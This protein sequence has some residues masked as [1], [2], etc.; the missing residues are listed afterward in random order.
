MISGVSTSP[1][2]TL[3]PF[4]SSLASRA[5]LSQEAEPVKGTTA[6]SSAELTEEEKAQVEQLKKIDKEVR[7]HEQA[8]KNAGGQYAGS[9]TFSYQAGPD[10][11]RYA[12]SGEVPIDIAPVAGDPKATIAKM[13]AVSAAAMAPAQPSGQD[14]KVAAM[15]AS[16]R[17][18]AQAELAQEFRA[19]LSGESKGE[20]EGGAVNSVTLSAFAAYDAG[21]ATEKSEKTSG[22]ILDFF[23]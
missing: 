5:K 1:V 3:R 2:Q 11:R 10:G 20:D 4:A 17:A 13:N 12:V 6:Q 8:H 19:K 21:S 18:E 7:A 14:R 15:A 23:S 22:N 16:L 9:A